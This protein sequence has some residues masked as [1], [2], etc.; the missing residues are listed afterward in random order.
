MTIDD[1]RQILA[2]EGYVAIDE[3]HDGVNVMYPVHAHGEHTAHIVVGG[4][5]FITING[6]E[7]EYVPGDRCDIPAHVAHSVRM[8]GEGCTYIF[9]EKV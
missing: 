7:M 8:G 4:S 5:I 2:N 6:E 1:A 3:W 9:G